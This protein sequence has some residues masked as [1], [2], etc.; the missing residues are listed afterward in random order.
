MK[1]LCVVYVEPP[2]L[3]AL[4]PDQQAQLKRDSLAYDVELQRMGKYIVANALAPV[5]TARTLRIRHG[6]ASWTDGPF[7]ETKEVLGGFILVDAA[8]MDEAAKLATGIPMANF[9][10]IEVRPI[11]ELKT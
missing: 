5:S 10:S 2:T 11:M 7:A 3:A 6:K 8:N 1:F 9:G 4:S